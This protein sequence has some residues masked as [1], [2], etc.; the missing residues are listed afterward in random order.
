MK[1]AKKWNEEVATLPIVLRKHSINYKY[2]KKQIKHAK[3]NSI[4]DAL[5]Q[6]Q[7]ECKQVD[8]TFCKCFSHCTKR[9]HMSCFGWHIHDKTVSI[10]SLQHYA[11][12]NSTTVYKIS[13]KLSKS[14]ATTSGSSWLETIRTQNAFQFISGAYRSYIS[15][16][17]HK[18]IE[19]PICLND[20]GDITH[21]TQFFVLPCG[22][23][24]CAECAFTVT[25]TQD[26]YGTWYNR[27]RNAKNTICPV[28]RSSTAFA[29]TSRIIT[30][31][32]VP[33]HIE[34]A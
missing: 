18:S 9:P 17:L 2:W 6:L 19:C 5:Q 14:F 28:C 31:R 11:S 20:T 4:D 10:S 29:N 23:I 25:S 24:V 12:L 34:Y 7:R 27:F 8:K 1:Y 15:V 33:T 32:V 21:V 22:H 26:V 30:F 13:K 16:M 3:Y